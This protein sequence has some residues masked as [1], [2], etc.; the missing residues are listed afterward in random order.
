MVDCSK[1]RYAVLL[2]TG[3]IRKFKNNFEQNEIGDPALIQQVTQQ[4]IVIFSLLML[5]L[6]SFTKF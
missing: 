5:L 2:F 3:K 1:I 4:G 6:G